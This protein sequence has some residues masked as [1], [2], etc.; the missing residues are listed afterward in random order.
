MAGLG[1]VDSIEGLMAQY[2][3]NFNAQAVNGQL[4]ILGQGPPTTETQLRESAAGQGP[5]VFEVDVEVEGDKFTETDLREYIVGLDPTELLTLQQGLFSEGYYGTIDDISE[6]EDPINTGRALRQ[7]AKDAAVAFEQGAAT[8]MEAAPTLE[9][10]FAE[11]TIEDLDVAKDEF[12]QKEKQSVT[13]VMPSSA[14]DRM[15]EDTW[16]KLLGRKPTAEERRAA[17]GAVRVAQVAAGEAMQQ[18][19]G[20]IVEQVD[21]TGIL[22]Q[23]AGAADPARADAMSLSSSAATLKRVLGLR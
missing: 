21:V 20:G 19:E 10:R 11:F 13:R 22:E 18:Q 6:L 12:L 5:P 4:L 17:F 16:K 2:A 8:G 3:Y 14:V 1:D 23:K 9:G 7:A 15:V